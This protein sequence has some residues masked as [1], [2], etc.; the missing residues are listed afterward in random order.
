MLQYASIMLYAAC[1]KYGGII[2]SS[3]MIGARITNSNWSEHMWLELRKGVFHTHPLWWFI[4]SGVPTYGDTL[5]VAG[6]MKR[7]FANTSNSMKA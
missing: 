2:N 3:L 7:G 4:T 1:L 6:S 5:C